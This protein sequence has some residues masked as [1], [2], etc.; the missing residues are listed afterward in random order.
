M[1][2]VQCNQLDTRYLTKHVRKPV[3]GM[4][5]CYLLL[6]F[7]KLSF[8][9]WKSILLSPYITSIPTIIATLLMSPLGNYRGSGKRLTGFLIYF[10]YPFICWSTALLRS[11]NIHTYFVIFLTER[12]VVTYFLPKFIGHQ[13]LIIFK[14]LTTKSYYW[15]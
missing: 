8:D 6:S 12:I 1:E 10:S 14:S 15:P 3:T 13:F 2:V 7:W 5:Y 9:E 11:H 4:K